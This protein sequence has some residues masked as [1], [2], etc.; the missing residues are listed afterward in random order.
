MRAVKFVGNSC[1]EVVDAPEPKA[2]RGWVIV[3][4]KASLICGS[5]MFAYFS[6]KEREFTPGHEISG[7]VIEVGEGVSEIRPNDRGYGDQ[8]RCPKGEIGYFV[9]MPNIWAD[10]MTEVMLSM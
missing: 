10:T 5:D 7:E 3:K 1:V 4:V 6:A 2:N 8:T 9:R